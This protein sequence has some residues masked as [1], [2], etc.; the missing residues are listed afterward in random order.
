MHP[1]TAILSVLFLAAAGTAGAQ[2]AVLL[3]LG[4]RVGE[5]VHSRVVMNTFMR[6]GPMAAMAGDTSLPTM[7]ATM[8]LTNTLRTIA[9]DTLL[10]AGA[11]DSVQIESPGMPGLASMLQGTAATARRRLTV[12]VDVRG[13]VLAVDTSGSATP[14]G[15]TGSGTAGFLGSSSPNG[16]GF[17]FPERGI[18][19]GESW[20]DSATVVSQQLGGEIRSRHV[21]R[22]E[23]VEP[24]GDSGTA[25]ITMTGTVTAPLPTGMLETPFA[26][27]AAFDIAA[28]RMRAFSLTSVSRM[29]SRMG[30]IY[31]R[32]EMAQAEE[33]DTAL[34]LPRIV[35]P[36]RVATPGAPAQAAAPSPARVIPRNPGDTL[37]G[38][39][40]SPAP[41][42]FTIIR[43]G[44]PPGP[45]NALLAEHVRRARAAGRR[46]FVE[47]EADWC[48]PCRALTA[49]LGESRMVEAFE[50]TYIVRVNSDLWMTRLAD[51]G[52]DASTIPVF[53]ELNDAG[54]PTGRSINGGAWGED[55]PANM[56]PP[57]KAFFHQAAGKSR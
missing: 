47:F 25:I 32:V 56:A 10:F 49:S 21:L 40:I 11:V 55:I 35:E 36:V 39:E 15:T 18:R 1:R 57:L 38:V 17:A 23:R 24:R 14:A 2:Q 16:A 37:V 52:F 22:L 26:G 51:T 45:L 43:L 5:T 29:D 8:F 31:T 20:A 34:T 28:H 6:G 44:T 9:G 50:G 48:G 53:Y 30:E 13:R 7:R 41:T 3:R 4:G 33:G 42:R 19:V 46:A 54:R 27:I 12:R